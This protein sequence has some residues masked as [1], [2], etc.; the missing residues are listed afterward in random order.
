MRIL[1]FLGIHKNELTRL[2]VPDGSGW[3]FVMV[4]KCARCGFVKR[5]DG[6]N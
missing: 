3:K 2:L 6:E 1:C 4:F 5:I